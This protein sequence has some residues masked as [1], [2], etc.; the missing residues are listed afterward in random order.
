MEIFVTN[1]KDMILEFFLKHSAGEFHLRELE[2]LT[3]ISLPW[4]RKITGLLA[5]EQ[6]IL[7]K[8]ERGLRIAKA[9]RDNE[10]FLAI[11]QS[12]NLLSLYKSGVVKMLNE[13]YNH[14]EAIVLFGSYR[15]GEDTETSDIDIA[16]ITKRKLNL[17]LAPFEKKL[18]RKM[19]VL[20]LEKGKI[21]KEFLN[22]LANG[23]VLTGYLEVV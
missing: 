14:P 20:E 1:K 19:K 7:I 4:V 15:R 13:S 22:T 5:K 21:E 12:H 10:L 11:K 6:L 8:K 2:R 3:K 9:N 18:E 16:V 17:A 23:I